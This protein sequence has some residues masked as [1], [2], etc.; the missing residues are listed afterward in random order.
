MTTADPHKPSASTRP[1]DLMALFPG[2]DSAFLKW[3]TTSG[4][5]SKPTATRHRAPTTADYAEHLAVD[6]IAGPGAIGV[7]L[8]RTSEDG[9]IECSVVAIDLDNLPVSSLRDTP[10][11]DS[12]ES[13]GI[14]PYVSTGSTGRGSHLYVF[15][16]HAMPVKHAYDSLQVLTRIIRE[17]VPGTTVEVFPSSRTGTG[18]GIYLPYR[19][20]SNDGLGAN[21]VLDACNDYSPIRLDKAEKHIKRTPPER[22]NEL[23]ERWREDEAA[24]ST[25]TPPKVEPAVP[26]DGHHRFEQEVERL[27]RYWRPGVRNFLVK[28]LTAYGASGLGIDRLT[29]LE[30][31]RRLHRD[32]GVAQT[33]RQRDLG[34]FLNSAQQTINRHE[35]GELIAW[36]RYYQQAGVPAPMPVGRSSD[37]LTRLNDL[38]QGAATIS[39]KGRTGLTDRKL[40]ETLVRLATLYGR[41]QDEGIAVRV[42]RRDLAIRSHLSDTGARNALTR[43]VQRG[44]AVTTASSGWGE[45]GT[46][47]LPVTSNDANK[48]PQS[49][50]SS[51]AIQMEP[52]WV[53]SF[54]HPAFRRGCLGELAALIVTE[55]RRCDA[56]TLSMPDLSKHL[57]RAPYRLQKATQRLLHHRVIE[58]AGDGAFRIAE[59]HVQRLDE[60]AEA[61]GA[62]RRRANQHARHEA[63]RAAF[64]RT[65]ARRN[66]RTQAGARSGDALVGSDVYLAAS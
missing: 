63:E 50:P 12:L 34:A 14:H 41:L 19:G 7:K 43:L 2:G 33:T 16:E 30:A 64:R 17:G 59:D 21:P 37:L 42:S 65:T 38:Q 27:A 56:G 23:A 54:D 3:R 35:R 1:T 31:V 47:I 4:S 8:A 9:N 45:P 13:L 26:E 5:G 29:I 46:I 22:L 44:L 62:I 32:S 51:T 39:F 25:A 28:G 53:R 15:L 24:T 66:S 36:Y 48:R 40:Y 11:I 61:M 49:T 20:A 52:D 55:L 57:E 6:A 10:I 60:A 58:H 18:K